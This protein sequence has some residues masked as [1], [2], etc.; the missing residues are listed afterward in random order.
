MKSLIAEGHNSDTAIDRIYSV[1]GRGG[2]NTVI[3]KMLLQDRK[4]GI[5]R[6]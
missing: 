6:L 2:S 4:A 1:Y 3:I 5:N